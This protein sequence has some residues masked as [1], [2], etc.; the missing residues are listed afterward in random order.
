MTAVALGADAICLIGLAAKRPIHEGGFMF[1]RST[2]RSP[3]FKDG[4]KSAA[5]VEP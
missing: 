5:Q 3:V 4:V 2:A 1:T